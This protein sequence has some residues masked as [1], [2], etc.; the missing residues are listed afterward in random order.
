[1]KNSFNVLL[2]FCF[3]LPVL[4]CHGQK[5]FGS[6]QLTLKQTIPLPGVEGRIDHM[7]VDLRRRIIYICALGNNSLEAVDL[8]SGKVLH[9]IKGLDEPQGTTYIPQINEIMVANG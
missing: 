5:P 2:L 8:A 7:D 6:E 1:M 3:L 4:S 9:S